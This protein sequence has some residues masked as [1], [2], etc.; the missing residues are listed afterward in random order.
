MRPPSGRRSNL[1]AQ[2]TMTSP[3]RAQEAATA[4][5]ASD[6]ATDGRHG[7]DSDCVPTRPTVV[8]RSASGTNRSESGAAAVQQCSRRKKAAPRNHLAGG[9]LPS[10][11]LSVFLAAA[12][13]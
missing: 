4:G 8:R 13:P 11:R 2:A 12:E 10:A 7:A 9:R 5:A 3:S 1:P 6:S